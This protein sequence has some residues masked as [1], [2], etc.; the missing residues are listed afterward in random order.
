MA[1]NKAAASSPNWPGI[2][3]D[4]IPDNM[5]SKSPL[6]LN[7]IDNK[8]TIHFVSQGLSTLDV[9]GKENPIAKMIISI[10]GIVGEMEKVQP[11]VQPIPS[12]RLTV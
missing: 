2:N 8:I 12:Q 1:G 5:F 10:L 6:V 4:W 7:F 9:D 11:P 3:G